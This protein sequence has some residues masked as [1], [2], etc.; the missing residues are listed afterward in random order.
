MRLHPEIIGTA[1]RIGVLRDLF[2]TMRAYGDVWFATGAQA[3]SWWR[4]RYH[5]NE[6]GHPV[7]VFER[8]R[9]TVV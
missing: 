5:A 2:A 8:H 7:E 9:N 4:E 6:P 1:G 3:A